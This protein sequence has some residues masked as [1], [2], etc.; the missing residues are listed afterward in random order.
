MWE[1]LVIEDGEP[2]GVILGGEEHG[3]ARRKNN[4]VQGTKNI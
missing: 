4:Q 1:Y 2:I 3:N